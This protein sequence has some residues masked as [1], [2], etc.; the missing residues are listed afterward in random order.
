MVMAAAAA[1]AG[2]GAAAV[3]WQVPVK[4]LWWQQLPAGSRVVLAAQ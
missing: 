1:A 4:W 3:V 2:G